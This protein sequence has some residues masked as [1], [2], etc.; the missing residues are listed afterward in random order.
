MQT[1]L[2]PRELTKATLKAERE[3]PPQEGFQLELFCP[4]WLT[5]QVFVGSF[6]SS[7]LY[8]ERES[9]HPPAGRH[10][11]GTF[12]RIVSN[13]ELLKMRPDFTGTYWK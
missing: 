12:P 9:N 13:S 2:Y 1:S 7:S 10:P 6:L 3:F 4:E 5:H 11:K 8:R